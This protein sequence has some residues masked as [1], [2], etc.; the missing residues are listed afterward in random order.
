MDLKK[1]LEKEN[2]KLKEMR[3]NMRE[4]APGICVCV[5]LYLCLLMRCID[6]RLRCIFNVYICTDD[7]VL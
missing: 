5:V 2:V 1:P 3:E 7:A 4:N 6:D